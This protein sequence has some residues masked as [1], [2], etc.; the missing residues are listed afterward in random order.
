MEIKLDVEKMC[1]L[2]NLDTKLVLKD[3]AKVRII[4]F[5][6]VRNQ[7]SSPLLSYK[8]TVYS[9]KALRCVY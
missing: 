1:Q 6:T 8:S 9:V 3:C 4:T 5:R 2:V 7:T